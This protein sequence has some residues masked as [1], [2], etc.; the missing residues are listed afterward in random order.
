MHNLIALLSVYYTCD[1]AAALNQLSVDDAV[2]CS[3]VYESV[4]LRFL[5][6]A[7]LTEVSGATTTDRAAAL[8]RGYLRFKSWEAA[9]ADLIHT[10]R[11][12]TIGE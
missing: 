10:I 6:E 5:S 11:A 2:R 3:L 1:A 12:G 9:N 8:R 7:E 4:K